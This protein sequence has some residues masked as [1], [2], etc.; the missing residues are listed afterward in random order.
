ML[1]A[2]QAAM[3]KELQAAML[4]ALRDERAPWNDKRQQ[5][6]VAAQHGA[7]AGAR[8]DIGPEATDSDMR[9]ATSNGQTSRAPCRA[10]RLA[11]VLATRMS[12]ISTARFWPRHCPSAPLLAACQQPSG[13]ARHPAAHPSTPVSQPTARDPAMALQC[14]ST[15]AIAVCVPVE[16]SLLATSIVHSASF[17]V[18]IEPQWRYLMAVKID[19]C[20]LD[21]LFSQ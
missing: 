17:R 2:L 9:S 8:R 19:D 16:M 5:R 12:W 4:K 3:P 14:A 11:L 10:G 15:V 21:L 20:A 13:S 7:G 6:P 1:A 18:L